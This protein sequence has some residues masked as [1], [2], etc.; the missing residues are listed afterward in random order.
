MVQRV[1]VEPTKGDFQLRTLIAHGLEDRAVTS[2]FKLVALRGI[3]P[4]I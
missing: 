1:G 4:T 2:A 3:E